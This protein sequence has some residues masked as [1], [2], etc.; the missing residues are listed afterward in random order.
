MN[1]GIISCIPTLILII[2]VLKTKR[3]TE[4][5]FISSLVAA[6]LTYKQHFLTGYVEL[7]YESLANESF[8]LLLIVAAS[9]GGMI[10]LLEKSGAMFGFRKMMER[11]C[12][13]AKKTLLLTSLL[14]AVVFID[15]YLNAL[16]V[17]ISMKGIS[18]HYKIPREH[19]A[20]TVNCMG[21]CICVLIPVS[22][23]SAFAMGSLVDYGLSASDYYAAIPYMFY[24]FCTIIICVLLACGKFP[25]IGPMKKAYERVEKGGSVVPDSSAEFSEEVLEAQDRTGSIMDFLI[26]MICLFVGMLAFEN[27]IVTGILLALAAMF[28]L[29]CLK[30]HMPV[31][32]FTKNFTDGIIDMVPLLFNILLAFMIQAANGKMGFS[33]FIISAFTR[34]IN[35]K[36]LPVMAFLIVGGTAFLAASFWALIV[37]T[38][39]IFIPLAQSMGIEVSLVIAAIMSGVALGSQ[40]CLYSD[41]IFMV[42]SGTEVSNEVQFNSVLPYILIGAISAACLFLVAGLTL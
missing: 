11:H 22:S 42:A 26:P 15:D 4:S 41:A 25:L 1:Y 20:Y 35:P 6:I 7:I 14:G 40:A 8:Q 34:N 38:F 3:M 30:D 2:G 19:L 21:A 28:G 24:P 32:E 12:S 36:F 31:K 37:I 33:D 39:P 10:V 9:F 13:S 17:S 5:L 16:A 27:N 18:D 23:W 29:Y